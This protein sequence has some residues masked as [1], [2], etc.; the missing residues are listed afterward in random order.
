MDG[1]L[2]LIYSVMLKR[3]RMKQYPSKKGVWFKESK[4]KSRSV[5]NS[6]CSEYNMPRRGTEI[7]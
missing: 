4:K 1:I 7:D 3:A 6:D 5:G 2:I